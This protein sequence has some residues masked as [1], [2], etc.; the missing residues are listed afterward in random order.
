M[1]WSFFSFLGVINIVLVKKIWKY[2]VYIAI[3]SYWNFPQEFFKDAVFFV[4][5][6][7]LLQEKSSIAVK[8]SFYRSK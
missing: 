8:V 5:P 4:Y 7:I 1:Q 6:L 2:Y 3:E